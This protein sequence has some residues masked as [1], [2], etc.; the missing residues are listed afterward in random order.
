M[1]QNEN[2]STPTTCTPPSQNAHMAPD[3]PHAA[4]R[5]RAKRAFQLRCA[6]TQWA[7]IA[8]LLEFKTP[9]SAHTAVDRWLKRQPAEDIAAARIY[10]SGGYRICKAA[11]FEVLADARRRKNTTEVVSIT[12][13]LGE[14]LDKHARLTGQQ[15]AVAAEVNVNVH[16]TT[17]EIIDDTR[18]RLMDVID[19]EV[20]EIPAITA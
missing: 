3:R 16:T 11:L 17:A 4:S 1:N 15:V 7:D 14:L 8:E 9:S 12:R 2:P 10:T 5:A 20:V 6:D 18:R 13:C 19:A